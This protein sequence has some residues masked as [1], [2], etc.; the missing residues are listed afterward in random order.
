MTDIGDFGPELALKKIEGSSG[1]SALA[2]QGNLLYAAGRFDLTIYDIGVPAAPR[3]LGFM[4]GIAGGR[5]IAV[6]D[7]I[8]YVT[9]R[10][11]GLW[12]IDARDPE[13]PQLAGCFDT[14]ELATGI[15]LCGEILFVAERVYGIELLDVRDPFHPRFLS[16]ITTDEAQSC[17]CQGDLLYVGDWQAGRLTVIDV[18]DPLNPHLA[19]QA[20]LDGFADGVFSAGALVYCSTGHDAKYSAPMDDR[21]GRGRGME[22]FDMTEPTAP[23]RVGGVKFRRFRRQENDYWTLRV[24]GTAAY[25]ADSHNGFFRVDASDPE[26]PRC[27]GFARLPEYRPAWEKPADGLL[28][29][30][31]AGLAA[32]NGMVYLAGLTT[33]L[34]MFPDSEARIAQEE[35]PFLSAPAFKAPSALPGLRHL[36]L[37]GS[38]HRVA[39]ARGMLFAACSDA[40]LTICRMTNGVPEI[41]NR[42]T[43]RVVFDVKV[44]GSRL[45][46]A[47]NHTGLVVREIVSDGSLREVGKYTSDLESPIRVIHVYCNGT[48]VAFSGGAGQV[49]ILDTT[50]L[51]AIRLLCRQGLPG[52]LYCDMMPQRDFNGL[53]PVNWHYGGLAWFDLQADP[54]RLV[55]AGYSVTGYQLDGIDRFGD[56]LL[57]AADSRCCGFTASGADGKELKKIPV[58]GCGERFPLGGIPTVEGNIVAF[59]NRRNGRI[60]TLDLADPGHPAVIPERSFVFPPGYCCERVEFHAKRMY[61]PAMSAGLF[62]EEKAAE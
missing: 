34:W 2:I 30:C 25:C 59:A 24:S 33:G 6:R 57:S 23:R 43:D 22:I 58:P 46:T 15:D 1:A 49:S 50:D 62:F 45:F 35:R 48:R 12:I 3:R 11:Y 41:L 52:L 18:S 36:D 60:V 47:E 29:D 17:C 42:L 4:G 7:G 54:V 26:A 56:V 8:V 27:T 51:S 13:N 39:F 61:I 14:V 53:M 16:R 21:E 44:S 31:V 28:D 19:G 55:G 37:G 32:G 5:Q 9:G 20:D 38:V 40:G 10:S